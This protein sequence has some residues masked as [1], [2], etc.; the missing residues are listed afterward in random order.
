MMRVVTVNEMRVQKN[1]YWRVDR[2]SQEVG[3]RD[4]VGHIGMSGQ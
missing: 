4:E 3:S 1:K 2:L